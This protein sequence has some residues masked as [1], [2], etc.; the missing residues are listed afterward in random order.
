MYWARAWGSRYQVHDE[1]GGP[2]RRRRPTCAPRARASGWI[3]NLVIS[4]TLAMP[5][6]L[7]SP[8][9]LAVARSFWS[10]RKKVVAIVSKRGS[11]GIDC[12]HKT[13]ASPMVAGD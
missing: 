13:K 7:T 6:C 1:P 3:S 5:F 12:S 9:G 4:S 10:T 2:R 11:H 8:A